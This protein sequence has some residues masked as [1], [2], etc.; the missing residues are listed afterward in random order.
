MACNSPELFDDGLGFNATAECQ[1]DQAGD[2]FGV[3]GGAA[4][5][6]T[7]DGEDLEGPAFVVV[8]DD[9]DVAA[10][11][12]ELVGLA[13]EDFWSWFRSGHFTPTLCSRRPSGACGACLCPG[14]R[15]GQRAPMTTSC[16]R[17]G[18][19]SFQY[20]SGRSRPRWVSS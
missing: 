18:V 20:R 11:G 12:L 7:H 2:G 5:R 10:A 17:D 9:V 8:D 16:L 1:G 13:G 14:L 15:R 6:L 3:G 19:H 4:S